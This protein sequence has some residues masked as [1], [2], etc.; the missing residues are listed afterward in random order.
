MDGRRFRVPVAICNMDDLHFLRRRLIPL[1]EY[2]KEINKCLD[3]KRFVDR[4][5]LEGAILAEI[6]RAG[7]LKGV[8]SIRD[9]R[10]RLLEH[11][12]LAFG[13]QVLASKKRV[14]KTGEIKNEICRLDP[15][16]KVYAVIGGRLVSCKGNNFRL[17]YA[18]A[19]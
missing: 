13:R 8:Y 10:R 18:Y 3:A 17:R 5:R 6:K 15:T 19:E 9:L 2:F 4:R 12:R 1:D 14:E 7:L 16:V 11:K